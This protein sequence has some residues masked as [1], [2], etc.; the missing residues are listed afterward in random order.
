[1]PRHRKKSHGHKSKMAY[2]RSFIGKRKK[3]YSNKKNRDLNYLT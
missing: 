3:R 1:M 2:V